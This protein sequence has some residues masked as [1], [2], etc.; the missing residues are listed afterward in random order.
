MK[1]RAFLGA[2]AAGFLAA[3]RAADASQLGKGFA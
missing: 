1:R 2:L 3:P